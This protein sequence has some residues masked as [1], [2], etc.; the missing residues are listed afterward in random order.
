MPE[1]RTGHGRT[2][3]D[4]RSPFVVGVRQFDR[5]PG[6][7]RETQLRVPA[8]ADLGLDMIRVPEG[9]ELDLDLRLEAV[10]EGVYASGTVT[11]QV[12]GECGRCLEPID[13][14][15]VVDL[16]ELY[17][18]DTSTTAETTDEEEVARLHDDTLDLEEPV[19]TAIVLAL[20]A[21][22][23]CRPDC[24]GLCPDCGGRLDDLPAGHAHQQAD[25]RWQALQTLAEPTVGSEDQGR[26]ARPH[27]QKEN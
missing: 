23:V 13:T 8:P 18:F 15:L 17:V 4:H 7:M 10:S 14:E 9:S 20:P 19:R 3:V 2:G 11:A 22:P 16:Q 25:P 12:V 27:R 24:A 26:D 1:N 6:E 5:Q 21:N